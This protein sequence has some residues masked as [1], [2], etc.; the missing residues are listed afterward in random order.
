MEYPER[1][2]LAVTVAQDV[3]ELGRR[4][5]HGT[6]RRLD[7]VFGIFFSLFRVALLRRAAK[8][9]T[10]PEAGHRPQ[11]RVSKLQAGSR[12]DE[13]QEEVKK[14][15]GRGAR[16]LVLSGGMLLLLTV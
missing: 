7:K 4:T 9:R 16:Q 3:Q 15:A 10:A 12:P 1:Q 2:S 6:G 13:H 14:Q 5:V 8:L 11:A